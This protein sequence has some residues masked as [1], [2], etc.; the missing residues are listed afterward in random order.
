MW[1][2]AA[3][4]IMRDLKLRGGALCCITLYPDPV[5]NT[6][7]M[8]SGTRGLHPTVACTVCNDRP[9]SHGCEPYGASHPGP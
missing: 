4:C 1:G 2:R 9:S 3:L 8:G 5:P 6:V 7:Q